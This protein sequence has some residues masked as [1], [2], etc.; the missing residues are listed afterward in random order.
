MSSNPC[1]HFLENIPAYALDALDGEEARALQAHLQ[2]CESCRLELAS[3]QKVSENLLLAVS[4]KQPPA[5]LRKRLQRRLPGGLKTRQQP[6]L[7]WSFR[8]A[9]TVVLLAVLLLLLVMNLSSL[10]QVQALKRQ[11]ALVS[12]QVADQQTALVLMAYPGTQSVEITSG[13]VT[14]TLLVNKDR[15]EAALLTWNMPSLDV[16]KTYQ[17]WLIDA[18]DN[19]T[20]G[21][22]FLPE[23]P[24]TSVLIS[25]PVELSN[26]V[27]IGVTIEPS[28]GSSQPTGNRVFRVDF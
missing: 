10:Y 5:E 21:G 24:F 8:Q 7:R 18:Q 22:L 19:R 1:T 6:L 17:V 9:S 14:G 20:S 16:G 28:G 2:T 26:Y 12:Q 11:Q 25:A 27:G 4:P 3:F 23:R 15:K 13:D